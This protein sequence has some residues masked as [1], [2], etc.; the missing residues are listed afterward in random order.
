[1]SRHKD[2][3]DGEEIISEF[4]GVFS[5]SVWRTVNHECCA[6]LLKDE[7]QKL[8]SEATEPV[9]VHDH[10][11]FDQAGEDAFQKSCKTL[12]FEV[13]P[14]PDVGDDFVVRVRFFEIL[15][16][17]LEVWLLMRR[18]DPC[19]CDALGSLFWCCFSDVA[20]DFTEVLKVV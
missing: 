2:G 19:I 12:S 6:R 3:G 18:G 15:A 1:M 20:D 8:G 7:L 17:S 4:T 13:E 9:L 16:L 14:A 11:L 5:S 10:N